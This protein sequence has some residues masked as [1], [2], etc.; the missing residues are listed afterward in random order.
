MCDPYSFTIKYPSLSR[1]TTLG[2]CGGHGRAEI[3]QAGGPCQ[4][5][6]CKA[7]GE[8]PR[9]QSACTKVVNGLI[10]THYGDLLGTWVPFR[11]LRVE[12]WG[13]DSGQGEGQKRGKTKRTIDVSCAFEETRIARK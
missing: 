3:Q 5:V 8:S 9:H 12:G 13:P 11:A 7:H 6:L 1:V 10:S 4:E 2:K